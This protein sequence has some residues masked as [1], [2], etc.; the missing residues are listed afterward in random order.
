M[1]GLVNLAGRVGPAQVTGWQKSRQ[2]NWQQGG[3]KRV[4][5]LVPETHGVCLPKEVKG[6]GGGGGVYIAEGGSQ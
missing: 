3:P 1:D 6:G 4:I 2:K 5:Q